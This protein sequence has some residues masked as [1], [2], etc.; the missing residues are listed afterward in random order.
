MDVETQ[1]FPLFWP[2][3]VL[4]TAPEAGDSPPAL[5]SLETAGDYDR[6][7]GG[8]GGPAEHLT[9]GSDRLVGAWSAGG[10]WGYG[11][12]SRRKAGQ[13]Q[14][15]PGCPPQDEDTLYPKDLVLAS[16]WPPTAGSQ[17]DKGRQTMGTDKRKGLG[18]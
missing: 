4:H 2:S 3:P 18:P 13:G 12:V 5:P 1:T 8:M 6:Y 7:L 17:G 9:C 16:W 15:G 11:Q 14:A 10:G